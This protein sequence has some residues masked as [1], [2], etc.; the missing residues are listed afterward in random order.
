MGSKL[1]KFNMGERSTKKVGWP[2][3]GSRSTHAFH[4]F[5][6]SQSRGQRFRFP[7]CF[8]LVLKVES[9]ERSHERISKGHHCTS[10]FLLY[11]V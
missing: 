3:R 4:P 10:V 6:S 8:E 9:E 5:I 1:M 2:A 7:A 11:T